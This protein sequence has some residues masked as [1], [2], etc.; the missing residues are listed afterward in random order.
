MR[1][2]PET[3][4]EIRKAYLET[5]EPIRQI[6]AR[7]GIVHST[8][9]GRALK[10]GW[11]PR[12]VGMRVIPV[13]PPPAA[14]TDSGA[15]DERQEPREPDTAETRIRRMLG[16]IDLQLD[17]MERRMSSGRP[18]TAQDEERQARA[19]RAIAANLDKVTEAAADTFRDQGQ[20]AASGREAD[21]ERMR[22]EIAERLERLNAQ[23]LAREGPR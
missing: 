20:G 4:A 13:I 21:A 10:E 18:L 2:D 22:R 23:W 15:P 8:I 7:Y 1:L 16:I 11:P 14:H 17:R 9:S 19:L 6:A 12:S 5:T 3:W